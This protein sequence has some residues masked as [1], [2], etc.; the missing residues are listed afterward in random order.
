MEPM[1]DLTRENLRERTEDVLNRGSARNPDVLLVRAQGGPVV[2]KDFAPRSWLVRRTIGRWLTRREIRAY[3]TLADHPNVPN[4]VGE[5]DAL[6]FALEYWPGRRL[7]RSTF[8]ILPR[9]FAEELKR[10]IDGL[11]ERGVAHLDL[12]HRSNVMIGES[13]RKPILIDF[14]SAICFEPGGVAA[15]TLLPWLVRVDQRAFRKWRTKIEQ[16]AT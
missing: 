9:D 2:V 15:R 8:K 16:R 11:H 6:A 10:A 13:S 4:L 7:T 1:N 5:I 12:S 3:R 14:A